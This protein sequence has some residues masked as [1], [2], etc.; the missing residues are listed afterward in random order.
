MGRWRRIATGPMHIQIW[1][2]PCVTATVDASS[3]SP[4]IVTQLSPAKRF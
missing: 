2:S 4:K 1:G 3:K